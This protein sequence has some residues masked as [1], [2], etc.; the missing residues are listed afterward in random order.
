MS[1]SEFELIQR[2]FAALGGGRADVPLGVGDD[3]ALLAPPPGCQLAVTMDTLV[4]G[5]HFPAGVSPEALGHKALAVNLSDLAAMGAE[6]AWITLA[7]TLPAS[8]ADWLAGLSRGLAVLAAAH[9]VALVGGDTTHGPLSLTIQATGFIEPGRALRRDGARAGDG[10]Y[11][12][13]TLG[14][15]ALGLKIH[16]GD[17]LPPAGGETLLERLHRPTP[18]IE[19]GRSLVGVAAAA[20]DI[21]DGLLADLGHICERSGVGAILHAESLPLSAGARAYLA[22]TGDWRPFL[23]GGDDYELCFTVP[24]E[25]IAVFEASLSG[26]PCAVTRIGEIRAGDTIDC[27]LPDGR[28]LHLDAAGYDHFAHA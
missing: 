25:R 26:L 21:S 8:D 10:V 12:S 16:L 2:F 24:A 23:A 4:A 22:A 20:I 17:Y 18:R 9:G 7:L 5:V 11:V 28:P 13:G 1:L 6:P 14:D 19:L 15:A 3:C 27:R